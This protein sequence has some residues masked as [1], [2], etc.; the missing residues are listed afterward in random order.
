MNQGAMSKNYIFY[1]ILLFLTESYQTP[2]FR[3]LEIQ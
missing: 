3:S 2:M 1:T